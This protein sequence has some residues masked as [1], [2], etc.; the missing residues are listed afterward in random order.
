MLALMCWR[1]PRQ[2]VTCFSQF[3]R[4]GGNKPEDFLLGDRNYYLFLKDDR[5]EVGKFITLHKR[6]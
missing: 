2:G 3:Y 1:R 6:L 5:P 4:K